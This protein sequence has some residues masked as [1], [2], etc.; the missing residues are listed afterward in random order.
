VLAHRVKQATDTQVDTIC[1][2]TG[3]GGLFWA[4]QPKVGEVLGEFVGE[5]EELYVRQM[6]DGLVALKKLG[7]D[8]LAVVVDHGTNTTWRCSG[9]TA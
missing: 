5:N 4:H 6:R 8:P 2:C 9:A 3:G 7:T 1:Y